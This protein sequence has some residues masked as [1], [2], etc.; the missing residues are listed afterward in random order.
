V[1]PL[2]GASGCLAM[3]MVSIFLSVLLTL[4]VNL[5]LR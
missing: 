2:G 4:A 1:R 3:V 5:L